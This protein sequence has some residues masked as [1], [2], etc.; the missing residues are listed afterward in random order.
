MTLMVGSSVAHTLG[1][2]ALLLGHGVAFYQCVMGVGIIGVGLSV[3]S[4]D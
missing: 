1:A 4:I 3:L 2:D